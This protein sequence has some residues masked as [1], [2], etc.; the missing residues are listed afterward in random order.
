MEE[1]YI[2]SH[3][4]G[5]SADKA[6]LITVHGEIIDIAKKTYSIYHPHPGFAEQNPD[7]WWDA[8]CK[9][10]QEVVKKTKVDPKK[11]V[12]MTFSSQMQGLVPVSKD[13]TPLMNA[14]TWLDSRAADIINS[15]LWKQP[16]IAGYNPRNLIKFLTITGGCPGHHGKDQV[17]KILW[18]HEYEPEIFHNTY[19]FLDV[20]DYVIYKLTNRMVTSIDLAYVWWLMDTRNYKYEWNKSLCRLAGITPEKLPE[21]RSSAEIVGQITAEAAKKTGLKQGTPIINGAGDMSSAA[22]GSGA[23]DEGELHIN[24]GTSN[25]VAGH[26]RKR[27]IDIQHYAGCVGSAYPRE[28][29][30][31]TAHQE[32]AGVCLEWLK[33]NIFL[34]L[35]TNASLNSDGLDFYQRLDALAEQSEPGSRNLLF[36]PWMYG[37]RTPLDDDFVRAGFYNLSLKHDVTHLARAVLEGI[38]FNTR[39]AKQIIE[40]LYQP[41]EHLNIIGGGARSKVW[42]QIMADVCNRT[43]HQV[44][45]PQQAGARG[46]ALIASLTLGCI[47][48]YKNIKNFIEIENS[49]Y[50]NQKNRKLYDDLFNFYKQI[51]RN[52]KKWFSKIN[53]WVTNKEA[54]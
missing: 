52:N 42:C 44:K 47:D 5:T 2:V 27:K 50:P 24:L 38:A 35:G 29:Y 17:G 31:A 51:Y 32:T 45:H 14:M 37:E 13:G 36:T 30:L 23:I 12:G 54:M 26:V 22:I 49:F 33:N 34:K 7:D 46:I 18:L 9:T 6:I 40:K 3:D 4:L 28:Y 15:K 1:Q 20:K 8:V 48:D 41:V 25:W 11:I 10:T 39:W 43:I 16:K 21:L 53:S 19:K